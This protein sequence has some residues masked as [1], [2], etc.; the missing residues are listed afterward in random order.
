MYPYSQMIQGFQSQSPLT[1]TMQGNQASFL[2]HAGLSNQE[3]LPVLPTGIPTGPASISPFNVPMN[4][5]AGATVYGQPAPATIDNVAYTAGFLRTQIGRKVR[6]EFLIGT[7]GPLVDRT[8]TLRYV[9]VSYIIL[10]PIDSDDLMMCDLY[11]IKFV[12][13]IL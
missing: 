1:Q 9:G 4:G 13:I 11:S 7:N 8:G 2:P 12:T 3:G 10:Q 5:A 6:V